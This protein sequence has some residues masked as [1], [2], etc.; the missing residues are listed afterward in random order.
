[1]SALAQILSTDQLF[2]AGEDLMERSTDE[3]QG[4]QIANTA[5]GEDLDL[6]LNGEKI[7][8]GRRRDIVTA[9]ESSLVTPHHH[10]H[11]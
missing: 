11:H 8:W 5:V 6:N 3:S 7:P 4:Q 10:H 1:M 9:S 2:V